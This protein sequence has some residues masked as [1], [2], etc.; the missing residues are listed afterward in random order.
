MNQNFIG[1]EDE[2]GL[3]VNTFNKS[4]EES[5]KPSFLG[6]IWDSLRAS[7]NQ[8]LE[9]KNVVVSMLDQDNKESDIHDIPAFLRKKR[10]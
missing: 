1:N 4:E 3:H 5:P 2:L 6:K 7:N 9:R 8:T 10:D